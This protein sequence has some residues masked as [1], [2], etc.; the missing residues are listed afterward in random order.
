MRSLFSAVTVALVGAVILFTSPE[1]AM[2]QEGPQPSWNPGIYKAH[3]REAAALSRRN[4]R[5]IQ[6]LPGDDSA[7]LPP[8]LVE[9]CRSAYYLIRAARHGMD[10]ARQ[11]NIQYKS[12]QDPVFELAFKRVDSAW[13]QLRMPVDGRDMT[14]SQYIPLATSNISSAI[15]LIDQALVILP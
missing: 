9:N 2:S 6:A 4:L 15:R 12:Y 13:P 1:A 14:R 11:R 3:L 10:L 7:P 5:D 8:E